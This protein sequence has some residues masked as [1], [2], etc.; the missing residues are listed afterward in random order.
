MKIIAEKCDN[1]NLPRMQVSCTGEGFRN[2]GHGCGC[3]LEITPLDVK[4]DTYTDYGGGTDTYYY[5]I[6]PKCHHKTEVYYS[7]MPTKFWHLV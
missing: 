3:L 5:I 1:P 7:Q 2:E 6:C 4:S